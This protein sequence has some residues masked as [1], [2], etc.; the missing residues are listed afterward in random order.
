MVIGPVF[1]GAEPCV[2]DS[3][4]DKGIEI[5]AEEG[6]LG[7]QLMQ[8]LAPEHQRKAQV[9]AMMHDSAM[10]KGRWN[11]AD[12]NQRHLAGAFQDNRVIPYEGVL[13][14][15]LTKGQQDLLMAIVAEF[16]MLLPPKPL[17]MRLQHIRS[18][19]SETYFSW[20][21]GYGPDDPFYYRIQSPVVLLEFDHHSGVFLT[22][23]EPAKYH[24]HTTQRLPNGNDYGRELKRLAASMAESE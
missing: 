17:E 16:L 8:S 23:D 12:Q 24:I 14:L 6:R 3:G 11:P 20:I 2:I 18:W 19:T 4:P 15:D 9:Y 1:V 22:N 10:P 21:G 5:C 13:A 7:W